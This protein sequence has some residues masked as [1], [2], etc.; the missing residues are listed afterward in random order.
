MARIQK[1]EKEDNHKAF[2]RRLRKPAIAA[3]YLASVMRDKDK[4]EIRQAIID[5]ASANGVEV[6]SLGARR[7]SQLQKAIKI[8]SEEF[9]QYQSAATRRS[10]PKAPNIERSTVRRFKH[11]PR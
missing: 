9:A 4:L 3:A 2:L 5:I 10:A 1:F 7:D 8:I 11:Q 6:M